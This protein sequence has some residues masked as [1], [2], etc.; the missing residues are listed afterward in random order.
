[1]GGSQLI[2]VQRINEG[3]EL[4]TFFDVLFCSTLP[5]V[6][7]AERNFDFDPPTFNERVA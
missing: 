3:T 7:N 2:G 4:V 6:K 5:V 1:M